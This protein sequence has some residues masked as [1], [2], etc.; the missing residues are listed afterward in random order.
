MYV[1]II[2]ELLFVELFSFCILQ[3]WD[4]PNLLGNEVQVVD[5]LDKTVP[6]RQGRYLNRMK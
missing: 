4:T 2:E 3:G 6:L 1:P 5:R